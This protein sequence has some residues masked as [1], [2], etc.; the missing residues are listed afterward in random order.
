MLT[1]SSPF[2]LRSSRNLGPESAPE[3]KNSPI[4]TKLRLNAQR[5]STVSRDRGLQLNV[6]RAGDLPG[7]Q[8]Q[9][10]RDVSQ[11]TWTRQL[12]GRHLCRDEQQFI[13]PKSWN[14][15]ALHVPKYGSNVPP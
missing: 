5:I 11:G 7:L 3:E 13:N 15:V 8:H 2:P 10:D 12:V 6:A 9:L 14:S 4:L 1:I